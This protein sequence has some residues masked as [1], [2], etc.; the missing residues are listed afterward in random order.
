VLAMPL[1]MVGDEVG[2]PPD[3]AAKFLGDYPCAADGKPLIIVTGSG[4]E[5]WGWGSSPSIR[6]REAG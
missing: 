3:H 1:N 2:P 5:D 4:R 6:C